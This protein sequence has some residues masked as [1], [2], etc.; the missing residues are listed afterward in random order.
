MIVG[1][2]IA[3]P[4][5]T[6]HIKK[7]MRYGELTKYIALEPNKQQNKPIFMDLIFIDSEN[8]LNIKLAKENAM[9]AVP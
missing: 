7:V 6:K 5:V 9:T 2:V 4:V 8:L 3:A 1:N